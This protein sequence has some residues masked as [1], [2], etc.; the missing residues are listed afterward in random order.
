MRTTKDLGKTQSTNPVAFS[1]YCDDHDFL[2]Y[3]YHIDIVANIAFKLFICNATSN[4]G[5]GLCYDDVTTSI[6]G[7]R[8][9]NNLNVSKKRSLHS[10][11]Y[12]RLWNSFSQILS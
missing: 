4:L 1:A 6:D 3:L 2:G 7:G 5:K 9:L 12:M 8:H 10:I 11:K